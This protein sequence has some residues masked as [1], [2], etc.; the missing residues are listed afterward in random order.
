MFSRDNGFVQ[1]ARGGTPSTVLT[2][3]T[4]SGLGG[5]FCCARTPHARSESLSLPPGPRPRESLP[6]GFL[7]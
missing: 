6:L 2:S 3:S 7:L 4:P 5:R 1:Q